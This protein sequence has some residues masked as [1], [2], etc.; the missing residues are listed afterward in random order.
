MFQ[1]RTFLKETNGS[2]AAE[3]ALVAMPM[4]ILTF[5]IFQLG[6]LFFAYNDI[7]NAAREAARRMAVEDNILYGDGSLATF[8]GFE[9]VTFSCD[10]SGTAPPA[11]SV[12]EVACNSLAGWDKRAT[13]TTAAYI[14]VPPAVTCNEVVV[15]VQ[16]AMEDAALFDMFGFMQGRNIVGEASMISEYDLVTGG[17][18]CR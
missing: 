5:V 15:R 12:E 1:V 6:S 11:G 18:V 3:F 17:N 13:V 9:P 7:H 8:D 2:G 10:G 4:A 14:A 16:M